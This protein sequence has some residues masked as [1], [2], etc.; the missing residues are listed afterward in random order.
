MKLVILPLAAGLILSAAA[1]DCFAAAPDGKAVFERNCSV[2][3][4]VAPPPKSAPPII[5][6][7][8]RYR[9]KF[10]SK[11]EGVKAM[12]AFMQSPSKAASVIEAQAI[13]RFGLMPA[14]SALSEADLRA[15]AG[16]VWD[17]GGAGMGPGRGAGQP[18]GS[19]R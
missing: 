5:P 15:A 4:S 3:H 9:A 2:C 6:I 8:S 13:E 16:W 17:Q 11:A 19:C 18:K 7:A 1:V 10:S 14:M 12:T